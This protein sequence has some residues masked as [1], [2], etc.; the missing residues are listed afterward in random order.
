MLVEMGGYAKMKENPER[1]LPW[2]IT[3]PLTPIPRNHA[4]TMHTN[5][6]P[7]LQLEKPRCAAKKK[8]KNQDPIP[9]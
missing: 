8:K 5:A 3:I 4:I 2:V 9:P 1:M 6:T 7:K